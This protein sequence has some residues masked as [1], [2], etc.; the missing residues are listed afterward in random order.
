[1]PQTVSLPVAA[2]RTTLATVEARVAD[3][4]Q[5]VQPA[6]EPTIVGRLK[7][8]L[9]NL[10]T[11]RPG[12]ESG[13]VRIAGYVFAL[14]LFSREALDAAI[15]DVLRG[16]DPDIDPRFMPTPPQLARLARK[17]QHRLAEDLDKAKADHQRLVPLPEPVITD[18]ERARRAAKADE[19]ARQFAA[20]AEAQREEERQR[21]NAST[22]ALG[23]IAVGVVA[24]AAQIRGKAEA[25][26]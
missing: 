19:V 13:E 21:R 25:A 10:P 26:E 9:A 20:T 6:D 22:A 23:A 17:H 4:R 7:A 11:A 1:M 12:E 16:A 18:E 8:L 24:Q 3:L 15:A 5:R 14:K 2:S